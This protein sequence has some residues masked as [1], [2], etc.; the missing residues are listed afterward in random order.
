LAG[1]ET[2]PNV[3]HEGVQSIV[4]RSA[5]LRDENWNQV[6]VDGIPII[7][8]EQQN[9]ERVRGTFV[10]VP[11]FLV[12]ASGLI[13]RESRIVGNHLPI[14]LGI[15]REVSCPCGVLERIKNIVRSGTWEVATI[16]FVCPF[17]VRTLQCRDSIIFYI[18]ELC[19][20]EFVHLCII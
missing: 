10:A 1:V 14:S 20:E 13:R 17:W 8:F 7:V 18:F 19:F 2:V 3:I 5:F 9:T 6:P 11:V 15:C 12:G 16:P 4:D